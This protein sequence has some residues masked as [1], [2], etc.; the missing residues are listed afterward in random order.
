M[1]KHEEKANQD[2]KDPDEKKG[3]QGGG[4][5]DDPQGRHRSGQ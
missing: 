3:T 4:G 5:D 1:A 2:S